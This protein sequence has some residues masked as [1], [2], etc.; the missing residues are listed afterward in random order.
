M[1]YVVIVVIMSHKEADGWRGRQFPM[2]ERL[3]NIF[4][5]DRATGKIAETPADMAE[6]VD[7]EEDDANNVVQE[8]SSYSP[9]PLN[10]ASANSQ[11]GASKRKRARPASDI[12][13]GLEKLAKSFDKMMEKSYEEMHLLIDVLKKKDNSIMYDFAWEEITKLNLPV[14]DQIKA[15]KLFAEQP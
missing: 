8:E 2:Y 13:T 5:A 7:L 10:Q 1:C 14:A 4:G 6:A 15:L 3:A 12:A 9:M 11:S